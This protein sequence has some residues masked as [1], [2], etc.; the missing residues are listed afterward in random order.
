MA[1]ARP[2]ERRARTR[3]ASSILRATR[4]SARS[5]SG[6]G[7]V[8]SPLA[9][10]TR[11]SPTPAP[12]PSRRSTSRQRST[13]HPDHRRWTRA[14]GHRRRRRLGLGRQ[15][16]RADRVADQYRDR[17]RR[18]RADRGRQ[19]ADRDRRRTA[20]CCG[21]PTRPTARSCPSTPRRARSASR[22]ASPPRRSRLRPMPT[23]SGWRARMARRSAISIRLTGATAAPDPA[24][25]RPSALALDPE[26]VWVALVR[27][28]VTRIDRDT[29]RRDSD[30]PC[31]RQPGG[32]RGQRRRGVGRRPGRDRL[33]LDRG[34][35][36]SPANGGSS[37][38]SAVAALAVVDGDLW[39]AAQ[40]SAASHRGG[41]LRI[42]EA[43]PN[44]LTSFRHRS[45]GQPV[46]Q[47][48]L[49]PGRRARRL[50]AR[51]RQRRVGFAARTSRRR[52]PRPRT[53]G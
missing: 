30:R 13:C 49:A 32:Y 47:R 27:R 10:A 29:D 3:S 6:R 37:T 43:E 22:S 25:R 24:R 33:P 48:C 42:V 44:R 8:A 39:L 12:T 19:W 53:A 9:R 14:E 52:L 50:P 35:P 40:P 11:G 26:S 4:S 2:S 15:Q 31:R 34:Q 16:R 1:A 7:R 23:A 18:R 17:P 20:T 21:L 45:A 51:R 41:T 46:L 36:M 5:R 28:Q 38:N